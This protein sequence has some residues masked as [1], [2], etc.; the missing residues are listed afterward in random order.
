M[1]SI[2]FKFEIVVYSKI[3]IAYHFRK[4]NSNVF[5]NVLIPVFTLSDCTSYCN[6][7]SRWLH[8]SL[9]SSHTHT[10][11]THMPSFPRNVRASLATLTFRHLD[12]STH[13]PL[14]T[15]NIRA[16]LN[17][18]TGTDHHTHPA[19]LQASHM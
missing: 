12:T 6:T 13:M 4:I 10:H 18:Q 17:R 15:L 7:I 5:P 11:D 3:D 16:S 9:Q 8:S 2:T 14:L 1:L 19:I